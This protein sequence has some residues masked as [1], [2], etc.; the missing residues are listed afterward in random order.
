MSEV[1]LFVTFVTL[2]K[3]CLNI[4]K[5]VDQSVMEHHLAA[6]AYCWWEY[7]ATVSSLQTWV[8]QELKKKRFDVFVK[9][10]ITKI[11]C[12]NSEIIY[13]IVWNK[14]L[15]LYVNFFYHSLRNQ[16]ASSSKLSRSRNSAATDNDNLY[17]SSLVSM[18]DEANYISQ[19]V[20]IC[21]GW[22]M[23]Y[24]ILRWPDGRE[25]ICN[26]LL[27]DTFRGLHSLIS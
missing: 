14:Q 17:E 4:L 7:F 12:V 5:P 15:F 23:M 9:I 27:L 6:W 25:H 16:A 26:L 18:K 22:S 19:R 24:E 1:D 3:F 11:P 20:I 2:E 10:S 13:W 21:S 8:F